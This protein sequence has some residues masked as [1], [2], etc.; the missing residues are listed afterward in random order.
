[1]I[2]SLKAFE[3]AKALMSQRRFTEAITLLEPLSRESSESTEFH[4]QLGMA[5]AR[6]KQWSQ[7]EASLAKV[8]QLD[9]EFLN[10]KALVNLGAVYRE[11]GELA[12][13]RELFEQALSLNPHEGVAHLNLGA[14]E[15]QLGNTEKSLAHYKKFLELLPNHHNAV[16]IRK[17]VRELER[18]RATR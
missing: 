15:N 9:P 12:P 6:L 2:A 10:G 17:F 13:A 18:A 1:M 5:H 8:I 7:A 16:Q 14:L 3:K 4:F 11:R